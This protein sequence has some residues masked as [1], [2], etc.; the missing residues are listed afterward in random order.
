MEQFEVVVVGGGPAGSTAARYVAS[1]GRRVLLLERDQLPRYKPCGGG[2]APKT[3]ARLPFPVQELPNRQVS[4]ITFHLRGVSPVVWELPPEFSFHMV[5]RTD[6]DHRLVRAAVEAGAVLRTGEGVVGVQQLDGEYEVTTDSGHYRAP[7][8][9]GADGATSVVRRSLGLA[10][11]VQ[12]GIAL[13]CEI[14]APLQTRQPYA[15]TALF[16]VE[17]A[18]EGYGWIFPKKNHLSVGLGSMRPGGHPLCRLLHEFILRYDLLAPAALADLPVYVHPLPI[19]STGEPARAGDVLLV[20]DAAGVADGFGGEGICHA[21]ASG[22][23]AAKT[24]L[25]TLGGDA[26][27]MGEYDGELDRL[28]R[29]D[30]RFANLMGRIVRRFPDASYHI[31]TSAGEGRSV[32]IPIVLGE[33]SFGEGLHRLPRLLALDRNHGSAK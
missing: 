3:I 2:L 26:R 20:G 10:P 28:I 5:M 27:A 24:I 12:Q 22:E 6:L 23:L 1:A 18:P 16:D 17:A 30:H 4:Q 7:F 25:R 11:R 13:E 19:A 31:L 33:I 15:T 21:M 32:V 14:E 9:V 8:V 29:Q